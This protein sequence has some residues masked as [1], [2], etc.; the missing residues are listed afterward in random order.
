M[1]FFDGAIY[2]REIVNIELNMESDTAG[3]SISFIIN[4]DLNLFIGHDEYHYRAAIDG[5]CK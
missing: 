2:P 4:G 1:F 5:N 3:D